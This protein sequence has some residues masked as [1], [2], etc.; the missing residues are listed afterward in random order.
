MITTEVAFVVIPWTG[1]APFS[2]VAPSAG[3]STESVGAST[4]G[5]GTVM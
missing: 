1:I 2:Y 5:N 4:V 3:W